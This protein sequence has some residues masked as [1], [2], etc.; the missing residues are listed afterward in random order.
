[1]LHISISGR[2]TRICRAQLSYI[3]IS[4]MQ[5]YWHILHMQKHLWSTYIYFNILNMLK[6]S[7]YIHGHIISTAVCCDMHQWSHSCQIYQSGP[8]Q[9]VNSTKTVMKLWIV[10]GSACCHLQSLY[11]L[12]VHPRWIQQLP[13]CINEATVTKYVCLDHCEQHQNS[14]ETVNT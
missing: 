2:Q 6:D 10:D 8:L 1:M 4:D 14:Y 9:T 11:M 7:W 13:T 12:Y 5:M 3:N